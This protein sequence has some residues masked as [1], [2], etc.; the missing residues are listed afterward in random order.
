MAS[1]SFKERSLLEK[2]LGMSGGYVL[3]FTNRTFAEFFADTVGIDI[4]D[5][6]YARNGDSKAKRLRV[7]WETESNHIVGKALAGM[8]ELVSADE[9]DIQTAQLK[10]KCSDVVERLLGGVAVDDIE[11]LEQPAE[12]RTVQLLAASVRDAIDDGKPEAALDRLHTYVVK[13]IRQ[14]CK[15]RGIDTC[16]SKPLHALMGEYI[17]A[18][19]SVGVIDSEMTERILKNSIALMEAFNHVR[20]RQSLA[21]DNELLNSD[22]SR[23]IVSHIVSTVRFIQVVERG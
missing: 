4:D 14:V 10:K 13:Y 2:L 1:L 11:V 17:K 19:K 7:L 9:D 22:E 8:M 16:E 3:H 12:E 21:H 6:K 23:L 20:N 15:G 5:D 18:L